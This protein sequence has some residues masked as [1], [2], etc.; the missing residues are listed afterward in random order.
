MS[1]TILDFPVGSGLN[2]LNR[3]DTACIKNGLANSPQS[4]QTTSPQTSPMIR[5]KFKTNFVPKFTLPHCNEIAAFQLL[6]GSEC[7]PEPHSI[8]LQDPG[9]LRGIFPGYSP[10]I[11]CIRWYF[12]WGVLLLPENTIQWLQLLEGCLIEDRLWRGCKCDV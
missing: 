6:L 4:S 10:G 2:R 9:S 3:W 5:I 11:S 8:C 1:H 7:Q 12:R